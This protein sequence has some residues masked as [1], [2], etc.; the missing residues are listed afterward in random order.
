MGLCIYGR[1]DP[2]KENLS[3]IPELPKY[4]QLLAIFSTLVTWKFISLP[5]IAGECPRKN[6][7]IIRV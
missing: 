2:E 3:D 4:V 7:S 1:K 5:W 6:T